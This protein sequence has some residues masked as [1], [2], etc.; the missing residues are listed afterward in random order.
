MPPHTPHPQSE[1]PA[2]R[3]GRIVADAARE[4]GYNIDSERGG[5]RTALARD[6]GMGASSVGRMLAGTSLPDPRFYKDI[7]AAVRIPLRD[8][9]VEADIIPADALPEHQQHRVA[10]PVT[11][12]D[13]ARELGITDPADRELFLG[14]VARLRRRPTGAEG[15]QTGQDEAADG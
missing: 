1:T 2:Q 12:E 5:G 11:P 7:A 10:S 9:L 4:A 3:F 6:T 13:A 14:M 15:D 8:L